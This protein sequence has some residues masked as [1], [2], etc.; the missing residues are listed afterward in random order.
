[1]A[2]TPE[3]LVKDDIKKILEEYGV[4]YF[5]PAAN[6]YGRSGIPDFICC[7]LGR[8]IAIEAKAGDN[9][10]TALQKREIKRIKEAGGCAL[11]ISEV[12]LSDLRQLLNEI[13]ADAGH[14]YRR[15]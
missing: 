14:T 8:L 11:K 10:P 3:G 9:E 2:K 12:N 7:F 1:M 5:M 13:Q 4:W 15:F 6:G